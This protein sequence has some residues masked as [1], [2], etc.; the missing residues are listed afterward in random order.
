[1]RFLSVFLPV[2]LA[3]QSDQAT[4]T[5][6]V[7]DTGQAI[8]PGVAI[9]LR[10][11][12]TNIT[13]DLATNAEGIFTIT[14]LGPGEYELTAEFAGFRTHRQ[15]GIVLEVGQTLRVD[16]QLQLG[17][18]AETVSVTAEVA[19][20]NTEN[21]AIKGDLIVAAE[22]KDIPLNGR[23]FT[24]LAFLVPG[25]V[26]NA[27]GGAGSF[28]SI[29]GARGDNTNFYVD[30]F[31]DR[32]IRGAAAQL[33]P[34]IDALEQFKMEVSGFSAEYGKMAGGILNMVLKSG[35]NQLHGSLFEY[36]RNGALDAKAYFDPV[37]LSF[38]Q[39][40]FGGMANGPVKLGRL[41]NGRDRTFFMFSWESFRL[42]WGESN[43]GRV[44]S[45]AERAG[46][47]ASTVNNAGARITIRDPLA[48]NT[49]FANNRIPS[50]RF[51]STALKL[52]QYYPLP[53]R[54]AVGNN[55]VGV[56]YI[57]NHWDSYIT[58]IDHRFD[59]RNSVA[60]RFGKR[61]G[62][63]NAP[64]AASNL[65]LFQNRVR[66]DRLLGG[67][68]Y[69][70]MFSPTLLTEVRFGISRNASRERFLG[71]GSDVAAALGMEGSTA[72]PALRGFPL[73]HSTNYLS[74]GFAAGQPVS[75]YVT[76][77]QYSNKYTWMRSKHVL[78]FGF[79]ISKY[80][81][82]QPYYN[83]SRG[84]MTANG[85]WTGNGSASNGNAIADLLLGLLNTS[86]ITRQTQRNYMREEGY[87]FFVNDDWKVARYL[88]L[89][90][91]LRYEV[92]LPAYDKYDRMANFIP[93]LNRIVI[94][95]DRN[96]P[97]YQQIVSDAGLTN[98]V[99]LAKDNGLPR[100]LVRP[101]FKGLAPRLGFAWRVND[102]FVLRG[103]YGIFYAGQL[104]NDVRNG[105]DNT[106]PFVLAYNFTR[107]AADPGALTLSSP[108][109]QTRGVQVGTATSTGF[110][111]SPVMGYLQS[112]NLTVE[113]DMG[114]GLVLELG[115]VGSKGTKL[116]RQ[117]NLNMP[118]RSME[119][120]LANGPVF[121]VPYPPFGT[122]NYW[123]F[124]SNSIYNSGQIT[125]RR[126]GR[127]GLTYRFSYSYSKSIDNN[128]QFTGAS[129]GGFAQA[130]DSRNLALE[131]A[132]SDWDRGHVVTASF[133][134]P[135]PFGR[136]ARFLAHAGP[137]LN[138]FI[139]GWQLSGTAT[140]YSGAP[141]TVL[142]STVNLN[143]GESSR[144]NR[145]SKGELLTGNGRRGVDFPWF[146]T[147]AFMDTPGCVNSTPRVCAPDR[148][149]FIPFR[150][151]NSGRNIL[152]GPGTQNFNMS[153]LK[154]FRLG[155][156]RRIQVRWETFNIFNHPNFRLPNRNFNE[157]AAGI[158][159]DVASSGQGGP[160]ITQFA[161]RYEF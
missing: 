141:F 47:F 109:N 108:F 129:A 43:V 45:A 28:A 38:H 50:S 112:Y 37:K 4:V 119:S 128:S 71:D 124:G 84:T 13:R 14:N 60:F 82:N 15:T 117:Y 147:A 66:D 19:P 78:K 34:N 87:R 11:T 102:R 58:K 9:K 59:S 95:S 149:G 48:S 114:Q 116:G 126:R 118:L 70:H 41:Y 106:F 83:N 125:L 93:E 90:L 40:Q 139:G 27:Q 159:G 85:I 61:F 36:N 144:P 137:V 158:L 10:N 67:V 24:E 53:N 46:D 150:P 16:L 32:N 145:L 64:W 96:L 160:R 23:D 121:A 153:L 7:T 69:T 54:V 140:Y 68:D 131:R 130:L 80:T 63:N 77:F 73:V 22:I 3:A 157:T 151:G 103:G 1:M 142:D 21:G 155:E 123:D 76:D 113:R 132:R 29:N 51:H 135:V 6:V 31:N 94:A 2:V 39:N 26:P 110:K 57:D 81:F 146:A 74:L 79:D 101:Y 161:V 33:R 49:P 92:E 127:G 136:R 120:F 97:N 42:E 99:G 148:H 65:G 143:L 18:M 122:I 44:P 35:T 107:L 156:G 12:G 88:T 100:S 62:R 75:Y 86:S 115:F 133:N 52:L 55:F 98:L 134:A 89:N 154:N 20:L 104:L 72:D 105:L 56:A 138:G 30:G 111:S 91:G 8:M 5:G 152:D 17:S 25:V